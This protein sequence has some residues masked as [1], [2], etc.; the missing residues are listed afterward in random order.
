MIQMKHSMTPIW[1]VI[2]IYL[3][4]LILLFAFPSFGKVPP[5][6][7]PEAQQIL[8]QTM[9]E[10][11]YLTVEMHAEFWQILRSFRNDE[12]VLTGMSF[13]RSNL[14]I[15]EAI[16]AATWKSM[17]LSW[18]SNEP[19]KTEALKIIT[20]ELDKFLLENN[21]F[22]KGTNNHREFARSFEASYRQSI[23]SVE[24]FILAASKRQSFVNTENG[25]FHLSKSMIERVLTNMEDSFDRADRLLDPQWREN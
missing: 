16:Q 24:A 7:P 13:L 15:S 22:S 18:E 4:A 1:Y 10:N 12:A 8:R 14:S 3:I 11:G 23:K 2:K 9:A 6:V 25:R 21:P 5:I 19:I 20:D 17:L